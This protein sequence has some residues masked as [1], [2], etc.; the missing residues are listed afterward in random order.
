[1]YGQGVAKGLWVTLSHFVA[2]FTDDI[3]Y[4]GRKYMRQDNFEVRQGLRSQGAFT[5]HT[6]MKNW[7]CRSVSVSCHSW[8]RKIKTQRV[9]VKIGVQAAVSARKSARR[10]A[11]GLCAAATPIRGGLCQNRRHFSSTLTFA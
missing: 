11:S 4:A 8:L 6:R 3:R 1:M 10:N 2:T 9:W 5:V 7:P